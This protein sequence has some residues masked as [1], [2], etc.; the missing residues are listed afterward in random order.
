MNIRPGLV[1]GTSGE[2]VAALHDALTVIGLHIEPAEREAQ[3]F[4]ASTV[5]AVIKLQ[6]LAGIEQTGAVDENTTAVV[7]LALDRLG[8][9]P[10]AAGFQAREAPYEVAGTVTD[11]DGMPLA[12]AKIVAFDCELRASR[13]IGE[14]HTD[15]TGAYRIAYDAD[16]LF[17]GHKAADLRVEVQGDD[18]SVLLS[19][20]IMFNAPRQATINLALGGPAHA[21]PSEFSATTRTVTPL[22]GRLTPAE[23]E[24]THEHQDLSFISGQTSIAQERLG[25]WTAAARLAASTELPAELFYGL[26]RCGVPADAHV[27]VLAASSAGVDLDANAQALLDGVLQS[28]S[29]TVSAAID[30]AVAAN[31]VPASYAERA[32]KDLERL[33]A[34][35]QQ[36]AL[37]STR[38]FGKTSFASVL[39]AV[40]VAGDVQQ[41]FISLYTAAAG[42]ER[43]TFWSDLAKNPNFTAEQVSSLRFGVLTGRLTRGYL[44]LINELATQ[45]S[46]GEIS[47][48]RD[49]ARLSAQDWQS[50]LDK[51][52]PD[53]TPIGVPP[54]I[55]AP[56]P[57]LARE[58]YAQMLERF[59]TRTYPTTAFSARI[60]KDE[61]A[62]FPA[63]AATAAFLDENPQLDLRFTNIDAFATTADVSE[64]IRPTLLTAQRLMKVNSSYAVMSR[65]MT[66][67]IAS[68]QQVYFMGPERF[69]AAY[70]SLPELGAT[71]AARTWARAEQTYG[72]ALAL[73]T[74]FNAMLGAASPAVVG[75]VL[76]D[77][78]QTQ[79]AAF[80][81]LQTLFGPDSVCACQ[82]CE[83]V[84]SAAAYLVDMLEFLK[85][86]S[87]SGG[88]NVRDVLLTRRPDLARIQLSCPNTETA[89]P[90]I[91]LVNELL[92]AAVA[93]GDPAADPSVRQTTL[94]T[95]EL[96]ANPE[97]PNVSA[98]ATLAQAVYPWILPFDLPL[99]EART[100]LGQLSLSRADLIE[101]F[102][103]PAGSPS[104]QADLLA[105][106]QLGLSALQA[107]IITGGPLAAAHQSWDYWGLQ[108][109][110]NTIVDPLDP[111]RTVSGTWIEVLSHARVLLA[112]AG[113]HYQ[114]FAR[115]L[116]TIFINGDGTVT[117]TADPPDSCDV[118]T[119]TISGL[120]QDVLDRIHRFVRLW[121][122]LGW[123]PYD[124]DNAIA[125]L[126]STTV[127][128]LAE[129]SPTLLRQLAA[130]TRAQARYQLSVPAAAAL[131]A[132]VPHAVTLATRVIPTLPG[133]EDRYSLYHDLFENLTVLNP[134]DPIF[135]LN[136]AG[137]EI[138]AIGSGPLLADHAGGLIAAL[139]ISGSDLAVAIGAFTDGALTLANLSALYRAVTLAGAL[140]ITMRE[141]VSLLAIAEAPTSTAP[142]YEAI[143]PFDGTRPESLR[144]LAQLYA[145]LSASGLSIEQLDYILRAVDD[146]EAAGPDPVAVGTVLLTLYTGLAKIAGEN[147]FAADP[148]GSATRKTLAGLLTTDQVNETMAILDGTTTLP[149]STQDSFI[150]ATL[151]PYMDAGDA[152]AKLVGGG[153]LAAGQAR[154]EYVLERT[155]AYKITTQSTG[156]IVQTL[157]QQL[158]LESKT[159]ALLLESWFPS[160]TVPGAYLITDFL[161]LPNTPLSDTSDPIAPSTPG[162]AGYFAAYTA[163]AKTALLISTLRLG[164]DDVSWWHE[165]GIAAGWLDPT[166]LPTAPQPDA[167]GRC[168]RLTR[169]ITAANLRRGMPIPNPT[170]PALFGPAATL[171]KSAYLS[172]LSAKTGWD[173]SGLTVLC[174]DPN[175]NAALGELSL[176]YPDDYR[177][178]TALARLLG[179]ENI[180]A[181]TGIPADV[182][183]WIA[184][185]VDDTA[186][187]A[188]KQS[189]K[190]N[191]A[192]AQWLTLA[193]QLR[194]PLRQ[195]QRDALVAYLL[196]GPPPPEATRWL[197]PEDVFAHFLIDVE[198]CACMETSRIVQANAAVQL[199]VQRAM[200][201]L[202]PNVTVD[203][204]VDSFWLQWQWMSQYRVW[205]ANR[206]VF[207]WPENWIDPALRS[208][209]SPFFTELVQDLKQGEL[210]SDAADTALQNYLEK[211]EMVARLDVCGYFHDLEAGADVLHVLARSQG[212]PPV[213]YM[214][215]WLDSSRWNAWRKV[216]LDIVSDH[217]LPVVW[218][219]RQ[220]IFWA[221]TTVKADQHGQPLPV[222]QTSSTPAPPPTYHLEV[223]LAWSQF[224]Q[225]KWQAKQ[226]APQTLVLSGGW[227]P[228]DITL[229]SSFNGRALQV[230]VFLD[231]VV[232]FTET[233]DT[234]EFGS[235]V[236]ASGAVVLNSP[237]THVGAF[238]LG[239]AGTGVE[240]FVISDYL[241]A[242]ANAG[243]GTPV[244]QVGELNGS[245]LKA[246]IGTPTNTGF[247]GDW[248]ANLN[249]SF[250]SA[251]RPRV[252]P[253]NASYGLYG[254]LPSELV[255]QQA[256]YYRLI[257][258]HQT[259]AFDST[260]PFFYRDAAR[261]YF[262]VPTNYYQNGNYF[263]INAPEYV[264]DPFFKAEYTFWPF[265]HPWLALLVGQ[266][267]I[268]GVDALYAQRIQLDPA[269]AAATAAFDFGAYYLP[270]GYVLT[271]Y[272]DE[273]MA[274]EPDA[275]YA[276]YNWELFF[277][278]AF[279]VANQ[280]S[281]DQRFE[282]AK[283][284]YEYIFNP[285]SART[286]PVPQ[287][288]WTTKPFYEMTAAGY[289]DEQITALMQAINRRDPTAE[290]Q[291]AMWRAD[292]FDPDAIAQLRPV[293]YQRAI[294]MRYIDNLIAWGDQLFREDTRESINLATQLY[295]L[296][297]ELLGPRPEIVPPLVA[298]AVKT[299]SDLESSLDVFSNASVAAENAIPPVKV[300]V[301]SPPGAPTLP[302][303]ST[304]YFRIPPNTQLLG[305]WDTVADRLFKIRHCM[306][307]EGVVQQLPLFAPPISPGLLVAAA[308]A[309]L[310]LSS[311][312]SDSSAAV[313]P[314]RFRTMIRHALDLCDQV[315]ALGGE[316][317]QAL[318]KGDAEHLARI[319]SSGEINLQSAIDDVR[320]R[321]IDA[322]SQELEVLARS[323]QSFQDRAN[324]YV[325][326]SLMNDWETAALVLHA[327]AL[328]P[329]VVAT[330]LDGTATV[331]HAFPSVE[332]GAAGFG[333]S[334][335]VTVKIG[336]SNV[337]H[338]AHSAAWIARMIAAI[339]QTGAELSATLGQYH[340][341]QDA[342]TLEGTIA[343]DEIARIDAES[344]AAQIRLDVANKE[345]EAQDIAVANAQ[346][347]DAYLHSKFTDEELYQWMVSQISTTY[348]QAY[349]LAYS[350]AKAAERC[351][352]RELALGDTGYVQ[353]GYWDGLRQGL[354]AGEKLHYDLRRMENAYYTENDRELEIVKHV[355]LVQLDP[356]ALVELRSTGSCQINLPEILFDLDNPGH[357]LRRLK[358]VGLTVPC[359]VGP[360]TGVSATL[361]LLANSIRTS[362]DLGAGY[363]RTG[364][365]ARFVDDPGGTSEIVTSSAQN[366]PGLF[367]LRFDDE[368]Y[369]PFE[370]SGAIST[371]R[372][373]LNN[374]YPQ[375]DYSTITDVI[376]HVRFTARD[377]GGA[378]ADAAATAAKARL[379]QIA[380]AESRTG[381]YRL[382]SARHED[383]TS[384]AQFLNPAPGTDQVLTLATAPER[385]PFFTNGM[386]LKVAAL[387]VIVV[388]AAANPW[389]LELTAPGGGS[390]ALPASSDMAPGVH[391]WSIGP[392]SPKPDLGRAP[393]PADALPPT[394]TLKLKAP[395][396]AD[397]RSLTAAEIE[398]VL[399]VLAYE[400]TP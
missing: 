339:I 222:A 332:A 244:D 85:Q 123:D 202:E 347:A 80:P 389:T 276:L 240:A 229:K 29:A 304:L 17:K 375:F 66:D 262:V 97:Y 149:A 293:A 62:P 203:A 292:P 104:P 352:E 88:Q 249:M 166:A 359:V 187:T 265:Y 210:T 340:Q 384:W 390:P 154:F 142:Y 227:D 237:R 63:A 100:Y 294:V 313:P 212:S 77:D 16:D 281:V 139:Q 1:M 57:E 13:A 19:S 196:A 73:S 181:R 129:L 108:E 400:V 376:M 178:E 182:S 117:V 318:E 255:L 350:T 8:I 33:S 259:P 186:A 7:S 28:S 91:D 58:T 251:S 349:Q 177:A 112:R 300:N 236:V 37:T 383:P 363:P 86:R 327:A 48:A 50:L 317:L 243:A 354:L 381:L 211:L 72:V 102:Q 385:F 399:L 99:A 378:L 45:R 137:T 323:R 84:L 56:T 365:D 268:G 372:L 366:D 164:T 78:V 341:R 275:G 9:E 234:G 321:Q 201:G 219:G 93:P 51:P 361:T 167:G 38:G 138:A 278:A 257:T 14:S 155:L 65:L 216:D 96:D 291:V 21:Q 299:Y 335:T 103:K 256:D 331:A 369:L 115:L 118:A 380:L 319:R 388:G 315:R 362:T 198:M 197:D 387:D 172:Q 160:A 336:G 204:T 199:F 326:R 224:K 120:T 12:R 83:S 101:A 277:H 81:N 241:A 36:S 235:V 231:E 124:L 271:P 169:L 248:L 109:A 144:A 189:T 127:G 391:V 134:P 287:R 238:L 395:G 253:M 305:Y 107:D 40:A 245:I 82:E 131:F 69:V 47:S 371:W 264:Y 286:D 306:N 346:N 312:L 374:V 394:W 397:F 330:V 176:L 5:A 114:E 153:A 49:L 393:T 309:G 223:Q 151:G 215:E 165:S 214:R 179:A 270:T 337:G 258:P 324:F 267:N 92:E 382:F 2:E 193:K 89:L 130:V 60:V 230:D 233:I 221:I 75:D 269:A 311:V 288:F 147:A 357:Y 280:L 18:G 396:A 356:Y 207:L 116:N 76:P 42:R 184:A 226:V 307:I 4:G 27:T 141:L 194:D 289:A 32:P 140:G 146:A 64:E 254:S 52:Q 246:P 316:L 171:T 279:L 170:F 94:T 59:F 98:Y 163:L 252:G 263:S 232:E 206:E 242:M 338:A 136:A 41:R 31:V 303:L 126:Q 43:R 297:D 190:A 290:H 217:V 158:G 344:I 15:E 111:T 119:M 373:T 44:P 11:P 183:S 195:A 342:W 345:K 53:G 121:R 218:N 328:V 205:Q 283:H 285:S 185:T 30:H 122:R 260:L 298:P 148:T 314:Y 343:Q 274:F 322:A 208:S 74:K 325:G 135:A 209:A 55:D 90:Y 24:Q 266:L 329:Q 161:A 68:S 35:A 355:S 6:A 157:A 128:G 225:G 95:P 302:T 353:F 192:Q 175:N 173:A 34:L 364:A 3:A 213:Y 145:L 367:E 39:G 358:S 272:P 348:F 273:G 284:W 67:G 360:N 250:Q 168:Y 71:E 110:A 174:G 310:D 180:L 46:S 261:E 162:F 22:L 320:A 87:A 159:A 200:L 228:S 191:Y 143:A 23:L 295:V 334:P 79:V 70:G 133:D 239:G 296:A 398:D 125:T 368:R 370:A 156:L 379:G 351:L 113:L 61:Q 301:P 333:G 10:G 105:R 152:Q 26:F 308:A 150:A 377:G 188:I 386:D 25:Y 106:E 20:P 247:D 282:L 220:Y 132:P 54:F 392:L